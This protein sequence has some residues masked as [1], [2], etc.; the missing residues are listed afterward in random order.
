MEQ[1][2]A[3]N[4]VTLYKGENATFEFFRSFLGA[5]RGG[6]GGRFWVVLS[7]RGGAPPRIP[8]MH[9]HLQLYKGNQFNTIRSRYSN[10]ERTRVVF[11]HI[12]REPRSLITIT[13]SE[14]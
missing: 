4:D 6:A 11:D 13:F 5:F 7:P 1:S 14:Y 2:A 9:V 12:F 8:R 3:L 10:L